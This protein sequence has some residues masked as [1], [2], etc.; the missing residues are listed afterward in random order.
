MVFKGS[1][2]KMIFFY[3]PDQARNQLIEQSSFG[4]PTLELAQLIALGSERRIKAFIK[5]TRP[6]DLKRILNDYLPQF[7][8]IDCLHMLLYWHTGEKA[9]SLFGLFVEHGAE[10][11][12]NENG[13][14]PWRNGECRWFTPIEGDMLEGARNYEDFRYTY[15]RLI[16]MYSL[17]LFSSKEA[18][19]KWQQAGIEYRDNYRDS[20]DSEDDDDDENFCNHED[21][22]DCEPDC[23]CVC[24]N[25]NPP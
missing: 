18:E 20:Y 3:T 11:H 22:I 24:Y 8:Y 25:C 14:Y 21:T 13:V 2:V 10:Y 23:I 17:P 9:I 7:G 15:Q 12:V 16:S 4:H 1:L 19:E 5:K 6:D